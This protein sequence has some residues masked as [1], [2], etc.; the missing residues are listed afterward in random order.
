ML[1]STEK[2]RV[3]LKRAVADHIS[4]VFIDIQEPLKMLVEAAKSGNEDEVESVKPYFQ[5]ITVA[6][7]GIN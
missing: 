2:L 4:D 1:Q 7:I 6:L 5:V 3:D